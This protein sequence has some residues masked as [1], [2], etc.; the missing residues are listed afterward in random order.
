MD[1]YLILK[2]V[3]KESSQ[4]I[5]VRAL[6]Q[7]KGAGIPVGGDLP[8]LYKGMLISLELDG[9]RAVDYKLQLSPKN[10][11]VL[12]KNNVDISKYTEKLE[13]HGKLKGHKCGWAIAEKDLPKLYDALPFPQADSI[14]KEIIDNPI[15][16]NRIKF[17]NK[18]ILETARQRRKI[19]YGIDEYLSYFNAAEQEGAYEKLSI[20]LK[21]M[22]LQASQYGFRD[23][24]VFDYEMKKMEEYIETD[25]HERLGNG[26]LLLTKLE[27]N[28]Y[29]QKLKESNSHLEQEQVNAIWC[30]QSSMPCIITGG[31]GV[32]KTTVIKSLIECYSMHY[33]TNHI[34]LVAP[35][36]KASRRL[37]EKTN[38]P[39]STIHK[40]LRKSPED[41]FVYYNSNRKLP[42][43][44]IIVDES[45]MIDTALMYDLLC[46]V[47]KTAKIIFVGDHNQLYPVGY[48]EPFFNFLDVLRVY[49]LTVNHRQDE[50][51]DI[52]KC[53][54][55]ILEVQGND[56][57]SA[58]TSGRGVTVRHINYNEIGFFLST[59][60]ELQILSPYN[61]LNSVINEYLRVG[62]ADLNVGDK[63]MTVRNS[64]EYCNGDI[65]YIDKIDE[66]GIT[67]NINGTDVIVPEKDRRDVVLAYAIT[68]HKMQGSE[69]D[70]VIVFIPEEDRMVDKRMMYTAL[71]RAKKEIEVYY[72][73]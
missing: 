64:K 8:K 62:E 33:N 4:T 2:V 9:H 48:G 35:T 26:Y 37:A 41:S 52:L 18:R 63:V 68:I 39:A 73:D 1:L 25:I 58:V 19:E 24:R 49:R 51:T 30:L 42:Y 44:L 60:K 55:A 71:T 72:Y 22:A 70:K 38:M 23:N 13:M 56:Y 67:I 45:S 27:I 66:N 5:I 12:T 32:G 57:R 61:E 29:I 14:H 15:A 43:R 65:G 3:V 36:G 47:D 7:R 53:A 34:L 28:E 50:G 46:A 16:G 20:T 54:N 40:A 69:S 17:L 59:N 31:A 10:L 6:S 21:M 11:G